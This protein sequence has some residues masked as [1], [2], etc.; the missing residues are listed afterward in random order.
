MFEARLALL[1]GAESC[2]ATASGMAAVHL[3][4]MGL[5]MSV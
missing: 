1:E 5:P 2:R 3:A 4:L